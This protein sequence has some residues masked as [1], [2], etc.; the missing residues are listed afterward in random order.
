MIPYHLFFYGKMIYMKQYFQAI[1]RHKKIAIAI[2]VLLVGGGIF[3]MKSQGSVK[4]TQYMMGTAAR[5]TVISAIS[6][7]GQVSS[8]REIEVKP[9][10]ATGK[11][12]AVIVKQGQEVKAGDALV[13]IDQTEA[14]KVVRDAERSVQDAQNG[15]KTAQLSLDK[16][17]QPADK[18][19]LLKAENSLNAAKRDL[20]ELKAG[21]D[22][23]DITQAES[24]VEIQ[25]RKTRISADG[26]TP[27]IVRQ[28]YD[29]TV[30]DMR[31]LTQT[32]E[33]ALQSVDSI[34][35][36]DQ[37][38]ANLTY[39]Q[40]LGVRYS[41]IMETAKSQYSIAKELTKTLK[42]QT[43][44]LEVVTSTKKDIEKAITYVQKSVA[45]TDT[46]L[47]TMQRVMDYSV[48]SASFSQS[49]LDSLRKTIDSARSSVT[50]KVSASADFQRTIDSAQVSYQDALVSLQSAQ[51]SLAKLQKGSDAKD[52]ASAEE[53]VKEAQA[54][55][56]D[57][58]AGADA[59]DIS[60]AEQTVSQKR[61]SLASALDT[62]AEAKQNLGNYN[63][64]APFDGVIASVPVSV[65][66]EVSPT[67]SVAT[68]V[69]KVKIAT[70]TLNEVDIVKIKQGQQATLTFD[71][72]S[73]LTLAGTVA[74]VD[75]IGATNSGVVG[76]GVKIAFT[77][78]DD[79]IKSGM[80]VSASIQTAVST[81][82]VTVPNAA[83]QSG[84]NGDSYVLVLPN[85]TKEQAEA[86][87]SGV[88]SPTAPE[89]KVV[90]IGLADDTNT[91]IKS[92]ISVGDLVVI[93]TVQST[94]S[95]KATTGA[96]TKTTTKTATQLLQ[97]STGG[98]PSGGGPPGM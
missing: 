39:Q 24:Q 63:V 73:D 33:S 61:S 17:K 58:K 82:V 5:G 38:S 56:D 7:S 13:S 97:G 71:A 43:D 50:A 52:I 49:T 37:I 2:C 79:R 67:V 26:S 60:S 31:N 48:T 6:G 12:T 83:I 74:E 28:A 95:T 81:D 86:S 98:P 65:A 44:E 68:L 32:L 47:Q 88:T 80:S 59:L 53:K 22:P 35:G 18:T 16:V 1:L 46:L 66:D 19:S 84:S 29:Q 94:A 30:V 57:L 23:L 8:E 40:H 62:L 77:T 70:L 11:V 45:Q 21:S 89:R 91:E 10:D 69:T 92:G 9:T 93:K 51:T 14:S 41:G 64:K 3:W 20:E 72:V 78:D 76:Y 54:A 4:V 87:P 42:A 55:Y 90:T 34:L 15:V 36:V 25:E 75:L 27:E 85:V 96:S